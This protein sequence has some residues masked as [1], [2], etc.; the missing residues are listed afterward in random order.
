[1]LDP[2]ALP[3]P[4]SHVITEGYQF[5]TRYVLMV[6]YFSTDGEQWNKQRHFRSE[7]ST[8]EWWELNLD[9]D[10]SP[11]YQYTGVICNEQGI[12]SALLLRKL[13]A[14][15]CLNNQLCRHSYVFLFPWFCLFLSSSR[16][17]IEGFPPR[18]TRCT[19]LT[20][21]SRL[22]Q[23]SNLRDTSCKFSE[24]NQSARPLD[25]GQ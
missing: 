25:W 1:M 12:I 24:P 7:L 5:I 16:L 17:K 8:C 10:T 14:L 19:F 23:E 9:E 6:L 22:Q 18:R 2:L 11:L 15:A 13:H 20:K 3:V 21:I 4:H